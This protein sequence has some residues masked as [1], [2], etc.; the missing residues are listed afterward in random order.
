MSTSPLQTP[1]HHQDVPKF[2]K[3]SFDGIRFGPQPAP[4]P[5]SSA[6]K[7]PSPQKRKIHHLE[8]EEDDLS[9][10]KRVRLVSKERLPKDIAGPFLHKAKDALAF[11]TE[12]SQHNMR[13]L[14]GSCTRH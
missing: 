3:P 9:Q 4:K 5:Q 7:L 12:E 6:G 14:P 1:H 2:G 13:K 11:S 8:I 10:F